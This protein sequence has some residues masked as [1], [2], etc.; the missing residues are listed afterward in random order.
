VQAKE[1]WDLSNEEKVELA[2]QRKERGNALFKAGKWARA[3][4]KY[5]SAA[6]TVSYDVSCLPYAVHADQARAASPQRLTG[7]A[8]V[9][10]KKIL[11]SICSCIKHCRPH[12]AQQMRDAQDERNCSQGP[13]T[14]SH[15]CQQ[16]GKPRGYALSTSQ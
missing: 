4:A 6:D 8:S 7:L 1:S 5:K 2:K 9:H 16:G 12:E 14:C 15:T 10:A 3:I 13:L 11:V